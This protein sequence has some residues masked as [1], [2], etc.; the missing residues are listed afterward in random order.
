LAVVTAMLA[1][2]MF[3]PVSVAAMVIVN[4]TAAHHDQEKRGKDQHHKFFH[5]IT[6]FSTGALVPALSI[7]ALRSYIARIVYVKRLN[8]SIQFSP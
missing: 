6:S 7:P 4:I 3:S 2:V 5:W 8:K 1:A